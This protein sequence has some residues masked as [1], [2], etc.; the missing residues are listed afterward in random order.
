MSKMFGKENEPRFGND[1]DDDIMP[2]LI[3]DNGSG[4]VKAGFASE[5]GP[6]AVFPTIV[7]TPKHTVG[8]EIF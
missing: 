2:S 3:L 7:G 6:R 1:V 5:P 8:L 4:L